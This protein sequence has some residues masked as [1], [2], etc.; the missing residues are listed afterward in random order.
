MKKLGN[1]L[2]ALQFRVCYRPVMLVVSLVF[3]SSRYVLCY[4]SI[5]TCFFL[6]IQKIF[7]TVMHNC[8]FCLSYIFHDDDPAVF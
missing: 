2:G 4:D 1:S 3:S 7:I 8:A 6:I 5:T